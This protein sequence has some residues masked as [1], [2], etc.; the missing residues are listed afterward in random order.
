MVSSSL[1]SAPLLGYDVDKKLTKMNYSL[2]KAQ[3]LSI[4]HRAQLQG[5]LDGSN[6]VPDKNIEVKAT[7]EK[8]EVTQEV[9]FEYVQWCTIEQHVLDF[10]LTSMTREVMVQVASCPTPREVWTLLE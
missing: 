4:L 6:V 7:G 9:N 10:L 8:A 1:L 5:Y 2:W 3:V